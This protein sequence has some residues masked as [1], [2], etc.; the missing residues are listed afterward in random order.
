M[1]NYGN[2]ML[3]NALPDIHYCLYYCV[4]C[5]YINSLCC[6]G[7]QVASNTFIMNASK[8]REGISIDGMIILDM[9][10]H[11]PHICSF[12]NSSNLWYAYPTFELFNAVLLLAKLLLESE[13]LELI[14]VKFSTRVD[15]ILLLPHLVPS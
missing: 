11:G 10:F 7:K 13:N 5:Q 6:A 1:G 8:V 2:C 15:T 14:P 3:L 4:S 9:A 12:S